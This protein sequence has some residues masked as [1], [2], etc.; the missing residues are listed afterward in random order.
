MVYDVILQKSLTPR[1]YS[2]SDT[3]PPI[4]YS[5]IRHYSRKHFY[6][7]HCPPSKE[8]GSEVDPEIKAGHIHFNVCLPYDPT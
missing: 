6:K 3:R 2:L 1:I 5:I 8:A 7:T 4:L